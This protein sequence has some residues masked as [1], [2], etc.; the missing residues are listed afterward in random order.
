MLDR[1]TDRDEELEALSG[2]EAAAVA[3]GGDRIAF[4]VLHDEVGAALG[5][6]AGIENAR[7]V[8]VVHA[9][10]GLPLIVEAGEDRPRIEPGLDDLEGD[11]A[12]DGLELFGEI[13]RAHAAFSEDAEDG[14]RPEAVEG[15][16]VGHAGGSER[17]RRRP[18][19]RG[20][21]RATPR[22]R[23]RKAH[24]DPEVPHNSRRQQS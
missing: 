14:V 18:L 2:I 3:V 7:D 8:G 1:Q 11:L 20:F 15:Q 5:G 10:Q 12:V 19:E 23:L 17:L 22:G 16:V 21:E 4:D 6:S 24:P 9:R 13:D